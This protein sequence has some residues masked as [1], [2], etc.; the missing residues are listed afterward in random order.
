MKDWRTQEH[1]GLKLEVDGHTAVVTLNNPP[2]EPGEYVATEALSPHIRPPSNYISRSNPFTVNAGGGLRLNPAGDMLAAYWMMR[3]LEQRDSGL[4]NR[5]QHAREHVPL[6]PPEPEP[7][8]VPEP[9][10]EPEPDVTVEVV[11]AAEVVSDLSVEDVAAVV[12][13]GPT[14]GGKSGGCG[15]AASPAGPVPAL[16]LGLLFAL[17]ATVRRKGGGEA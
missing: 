11:P 17:A 4:P 1:V 10:P 15:T 13:P 14:S 2:A 3:Y 8:L 9:V 16:L 7:E 5:S 6:Y 12:E